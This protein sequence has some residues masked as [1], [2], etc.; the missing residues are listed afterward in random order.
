MGL[1]GIFGRGKSSEVSENANALSVNQIA[2]DRAKSMT[3]VGERHAF[4]EYLI[5]NNMVGAD[6]IKSALLEQKVTQERIGAILVRN[7]FVMQ[8]ALTKA[9]LNFNADRI[10]TEKVS[11]SRIPVEILERMNVILSAETEDTIYVGTMSDEETVRS[12]VREYYPEKR[13]KFVAFMADNLPDF[14]ERI[15]RSSVAMDEEDVA[16]E[17]MLDRILRQ[18]MKQF[19]SDVHIEPHGASYSVFFRKLGVREHVF[20][21]DIEEYQT[22]ITQLKD[23]ARMD[24]AERRIGQDGGFQVD[25]GGKYVDLRVATVATV[26][27]EQAIIRILDPD[28]VSPTL[29][30]LGIT[31]VDHWRRGISRQNGLCLICGATGSGKTTTLNASIKELDRFGKKIYTAEDPVEYRI[32]FVGQV[33]MNPQVDLTFS[34]AIKNFMRADPD[35][36]VLG[37][38]RDA[39]TARNAVKGADTGHLML[40]TLHTSSIISSLTRLRDLEVD[41]YELRYIL[42]AVLVQTLVRTI[43]GTCGGTGLYRGDPCPKCNGGGYAG[44][45]IVSECYSFGD[46]DDV[47]K[48]IAYTS[49]DSKDRASSARD[50]PWPTIVDDALEKMIE[51]LTTSDEL[52]RVFG[53]EA[54]DRFERRGINPEH[55]AL[56]KRFVG[57]NMI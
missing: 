4:A 22:V 31:H 34:R 39:D 44:R 57:R 13:I 47:D 6:A 28:R 18:A 19:A 32:P 1:M 3:K 15:R 55:Y 43:C 20:E 40:A 37:E 46:T 41:S 33:S 8:S 50:L 56:K 48:V 30:T 53:A 49:R 14:L 29:N 11:T 27:G 51:G 9:I 35:I 12:I 5:E 45:T 2:T 7:G 38:V 52:L 54:E 36:I 16:K 24:I 23:R 21:G 25:N 10:A 42:R 17:D 26:E